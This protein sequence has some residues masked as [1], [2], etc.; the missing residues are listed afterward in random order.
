[1]ESVFMLRVITPNVIM[2][3]VVM[4]SVAEAVK[5]NCKN[6]KLSCHFSRPSLPPFRELFRIPGKTAGP[7]GFGMPDG[8][9]G[10]SLGI[11]IHQKIH[12]KVT[13]FLKID[14]TCN[15][16]NAIIF[17]FKTQHLNVSFFFFF[18]SLFTI[19]C[20]FFGY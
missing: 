19:C 1:M 9:I 6:A 3:N 11:L 7:I 14:Q 10:F 18:I 5:G 17:K 2:P 16:S 8:M 20:N 12:Q 4:P 15:F 13:I